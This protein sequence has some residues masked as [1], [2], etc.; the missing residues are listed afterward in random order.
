M[1]TPVSVM[2]DGSAGRFTR[3]I[4]ITDRACRKYGRGGIPLSPK[5]GLRGAT[6]G[7]EPTVQRIGRFGT[8]FR[9]SPS[10]PRPEPND[11]QRIKLVLYYGPPP[12]QFDPHFLRLAFHTAR[13]FR[14][15]VL[16][17]SAK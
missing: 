12:R 1:S 3:S 8:T 11:A 5:G 15:D 9:S 10:G 2:T 4:Q 14:R 6:G 7:A 13:P 17:C 16:L